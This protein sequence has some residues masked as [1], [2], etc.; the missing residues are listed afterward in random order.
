ME[1]KCENCGKMFRT[2]PCYE[3]KNRN[4]FCSRKCAN[5]YRMSRNTIEHWEGGWISPTTGYKYISFYGKPI[6]EHRLVMM[7]HLGRELT[8]DER[9]HHIN[10]DKLDNRIENLMLLTNR[11][12][13]KLHAKEREHLCFVPCKRCGKVGKMHG[14]GL[15]A[16]CYH[17]EFVHGRLEKYELSEVRKQASSRKRN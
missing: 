15:C 16:T 2:Y 12:H 5:E 9:V 7:K 4:R 8:T 14:R 13:A 11:E 1:R 17:Y 3:K 6:E 10:G